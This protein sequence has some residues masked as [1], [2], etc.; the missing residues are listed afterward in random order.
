MSVSPFRFQETFETWLPGTLLAGLIFLLYDKHVGL[1]LGLRDTLILVIFTGFVIG[2]FLRVT[3]DPPLSRVFYFIT[4]I[5]NKIKR[6]YSSEAV[7]L[8]WE[9]YPA[10]SGIKRHVLKT[11]IPQTEVEYMERNMMMAN[12]NIYSFV[13]LLVY[14]VTLPLDFFTS[15]WIFGVTQKI[16]VFVLLSILALLFILLIYCYRTGHAWAY[17]YFSTTI[18]LYRKYALK[19][20]MLRKY[21]KLTDNPIVMGIIGLLVSG[22]KSKDD[23]KRIMSERIN[24]FEKNF[25]I[26]WSTKISSYSSNTLPTEWTKNIDIDRMIESMIAQGLLTVTDEGTC[27][28]NYARIGEIL[29]ED[30][31]K[32]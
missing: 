8:L 25:G 32:T 15:G 23:I 31:M 4:S 22:P 28:I 24:R 20:N 27:E 11:F 7:H 9:A 3:L 14:V 16:N 12:T 19:F 10:I 1:N 29:S 30:L 26:C 13:I 5:I 6:D 17:R 21:S 2:P 18:Y